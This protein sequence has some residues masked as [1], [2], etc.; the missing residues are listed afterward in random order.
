MKMSLKNVLQALTPLNHMGKL[1]KPTHIQSVS[2][3]EETYI[4]EAKN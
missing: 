2:T 1:K 3:K 4:G